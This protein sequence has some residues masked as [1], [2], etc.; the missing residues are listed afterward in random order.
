ML[1]VAFL[2]LW[3]GGISIRLVHLQITQHAW[4]K[5]QSQSRRE[6]TRRTRMLRGTIFDRNQ[7][8]LA[9][10]VR[11]K[12]LFADPKEVQDPV[13]TGQAVAK[14][15]NTDP[16][17]IIKLI[18]DGK[19]SNKRYVP[20][21]RKLDED[22]VTRINQ[23]LD[24][25]DIK[26]P[27]LPNFTGLHWSED[28]KR[29]Y[30]S[31]SLAAQ[32][33]GF[34]NA[35]D[36]GQAGIEQSQESKLKGAELKRYQKRDRLGRV[37]EET[38]A[39]LEPPSDVVLTLDTGIQYIT[40]EA[41]R[42]GVESANARSGIAVV[43]NPK[44]GEILA[45]SNYPTFDPNTITEASNQNILN[46]AVQEVYSPGSVFKIVTYGS[47]L[48]KGLFS[49]EDEIDSGSGSIEVAKHRFND[50]HS[51]GRVSYIKAMA[52]SSNVCAIKTGMRV[53]KDD[54]FS[55][56]KVMGFGS[57]T[58]VELP[59]ETAGIVRPP[60]RWNGDSLASMS[61][62]YE[63]SV[64]ALQIASAF[65]TIANNGVRIQPHVIK[66][67]RRSNETPRTVTQP[68][69]SQVI[70]AKTAAGL[71]TMLKQVVVD[72]TGR[73]AQ[74]NGYS[75]AGKTGTAWKVNHQTRRVDPSKYVSSFV[76]MA[77]ADDPEIVIAVVMDE[78]KGGARDGGMVSAPVF[79]EIAQ[80]VLQ[81]MNVKMDLPLKAESA[82]VADV[83]SDS[84]KGELKVKPID[85]SATGTSKPVSTLR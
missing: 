29:K 44:T 23:A 17:E 79:R 18:S 43:M 76:G 47:G 64:T 49:P 11:V 38:V 68:T 9:M 63:I 26:K 3:M 13:K 19:E 80:Q 12:T 77:P 60:D 20:L 41:L 45:M 46:K 84:S 31:G 48:E 73:R 2:V 10:S 83:P 81:S 78:P 7:R 16:S 65:A 27:D 52:H 15:L 74:L 61:I 58:G 53:G 24:E 70:T 39:D 55:M 34:N 56:I 36:E 1:V 37:Y 5:E 8:V 14:A 69:R 35:E 67:I 25:G 42:K 6:N 40:D 71:R 85:K 50:S 82:I 62:G 33:I 28:Q 66:E 4:L 75:A 54:F 51:V 21:A 30:P 72:G 22:V 59:G 32:V 57:R